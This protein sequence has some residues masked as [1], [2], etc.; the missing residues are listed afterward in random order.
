MIARTLPTTL[1]MLTAELEKAV[2]L[3]PAELQTIP[4]LFDAQGVFLGFDSLFIDE[5]TPNQT[6]SSP[7]Q[8]L[9]VTVDTLIADSNDSTNLFSNISV[10]EHQSVLDKMK[11]LL[12]YPA[13]KLDS[14]SELYLEQQLTDIIGFE[15][16]S[17]LDGNRLLYTTGKVK[18]MQHIKRHPGDTASSHHK[19]SYAGLQERRSTFGWFMDQG[20]VTESLTHKEKYFLS[21]QLYYLPEW[22]DNYKA[23]KSWYKYKKVLLINPFDQVAVV[24]AVGTIGPSIPFKYQFGASPETVI[25]GKF[26]SRA[27]RGKALA[28]FIDDKTDS[29]PL[30]PVSLQR[31]N[32]A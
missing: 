25:E 3:Y 24:C 9:A 5:D 28:M 16:T 14:Q 22:K 15:V 23:L 6:T 18:A 10:E 19:Y 17:E 12:E 2:S 30:G 1:E 21:L 32:Y 4:A 27:A 8:S 20:V 31:M 7:T 29:V 26:W 11:E 13:G